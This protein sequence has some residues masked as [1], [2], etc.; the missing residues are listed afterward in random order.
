MYF[1]CVIWQLALC[2]FDFF[3]QLKIDF[4]LS[5]CLVKSLYI[6]DR[7]SLSNN[8]FEGLIPLHFFLLFLM[9]LYVRECHFLN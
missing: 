2:L 1:S 5:F 4:F 7:N 9:C 8:V 6:L 3:T